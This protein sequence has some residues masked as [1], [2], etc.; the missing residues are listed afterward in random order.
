MTHREREAPIID[1]FNV[2]IKVNIMSSDS[3][4]GTSEL[5]CLNLEPFRKRKKRVPYLSL[6]LLE[7]CVLDV[8]TF[9]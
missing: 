5:L 6:D 2:S 3:M 8:L 4:K 7:V 1:W 9:Y